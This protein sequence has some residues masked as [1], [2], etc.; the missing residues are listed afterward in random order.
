[1]NQR[2]AVELDR[3]TLLIAEAEAKLGDLGAL[4]GR[5]DHVGNSLTRRKIEQVR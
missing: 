2:C 3:H 4:G 5:H 1:M